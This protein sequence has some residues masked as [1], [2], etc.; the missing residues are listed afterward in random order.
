M[1]IKIAGKTYP[2]AFNLAE[3]DALEQYRGKP[4]DVQ[5]ITEEL[6]HP[7]PLA[8]TLHILMGENAPDTAWLMHHI[9][10]ARMWEIQIAVLQA[11]TEGMSME[12]AEEDE[13]SGPVDVTL[14]E[15]KKKET[16]GSDTG[17]S[18]AGD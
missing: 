12:T 1:E 4:L 5:G 8:E 10:P 16:A 18:S 6:R 9:R 11:I 15:L 7:R 3:M 2:L 17:R 14:E 13:Q